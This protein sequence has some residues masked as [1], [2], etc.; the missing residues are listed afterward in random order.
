[1]A[2]RTLQ[3][4]M[5]ALPPRAHRKLTFSVKCTFLSHQLA[6]GWAREKSD[7]V[8]SGHW[9]APTCEKEWLR[10]AVREA[11]PTLSA[12]PK[13]NLCA[14]LRLLPASFL[15][16]NNGITMFRAQTMSVHIHLEIARAARES[17][18]ELAAVVI[19]KLLFTAIEIG[20]YRTV[21][22]A[23]ETLLQIHPLRA[24]GVASIALFVAIDSGL[25][26]LAKML[27]AM[28]DEAGDMLAQLDNE[29]MVQLPD[30]FTSP[31]RKA[32]P[33]DKWRFNPLVVL[34]ARCKTQ[35]EG[36]APIDQRFAALRHAIEH[37]AATQGQL[38]G[39]GLG[40]DSAHQLLFVLSLPQFADMLEALQEEP[41]MFPAAT[42]EWARQI[43]AL[44]DESDSE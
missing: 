44:G 4:E 3:L 22:L 14:H 24:R 1:M 5:D 28:S 7:V 2:A 13:A 26:E 39:L 30:F 6:D 17:P 9:D 29:T 31:T 33:S 34:L 41:E 18:P 43:G 25:I 21:R 23:L 16:T 27:C 42:R 35:Q 38:D 20:Q 10:K 40:I 32:L 36:A 12:S 37:G 8:S 15:C 19:E 11:P